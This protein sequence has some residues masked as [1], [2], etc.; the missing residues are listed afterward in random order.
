MGIAGRLREIWY[1]EG[2]APLCLVALPARLEAPPDGRSGWIDQLELAGVAKRPALLQPGA[3]L[4]YHLVVPP[5]GVFHAAL[6]VTGADRGAAAI[7]FC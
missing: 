2:H 6:A 3:T 7:E 1:E 4:R 5:R